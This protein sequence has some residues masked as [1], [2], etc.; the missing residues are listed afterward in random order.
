ME[1]WGDLDRGS[2][3]RDWKCNADVIFVVRW[4]SLQ[5][6]DVA[7]AEL[8]RRGKQDPVIVHLGT[9][10]LLV[11]ALLDSGLGIEIG[12]EKRKTV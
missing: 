7:E 10:V 1:C 2:G 8:L 11:N 3:H 4:E 5:Q 6:L 9:D 12:I